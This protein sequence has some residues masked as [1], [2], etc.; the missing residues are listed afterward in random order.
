MDF[1]KTKFGKFFTIIFIHPHHSPDEALYHLRDAKQ[2]AFSE[3]PD[4]G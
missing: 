2:E 4:L 1:L 3:V